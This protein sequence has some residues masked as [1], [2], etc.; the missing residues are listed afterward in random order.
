MG[1]FK[2][3]A[4]KRI[5]LLK[6]EFEGKTFSVLGDSISTFGGVSNNP[7]AN[8][9]IVN[10]KV[11]YNG[12]MYVRDQKHT[13]W[14]MLQ[15]KLGM[16]LLVNNSWSGSCVSVDGN[17]PGAEGCGSRAEN[18]HN[19]Q[20]DCPDM[21]FV[22]LGTNDYANKVDLS[23]F[24]KSYETM[25]DKIQHRYPSSKVY[26][27]TILPHDRDFKTDEEIKAKDYNNIIRSVAENKNIK[28]VDLERDMNLKP[29]SY[30]AI[31]TSR[32]ALHPSE[33]GMDMIA[34]SVINTIS[35]DYSSE[36]NYSM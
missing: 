30:R 24:A 13:W 5:S 14:G 1:D 26:S 6:N 17:N 12:T 25:L 19:N 31:V 28:V 20:G 8:S 36:Q 18:L 10:N 4:D 2:N 7:D 34:L 3:F 21:I 23:V 9:T 32:R 16:S 15:D 35:P 27:F 11:F 22:Y 29:E 33:G